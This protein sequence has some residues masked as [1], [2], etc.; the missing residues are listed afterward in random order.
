MEPTTIPLVHII[1]HGQALHNVDRGYPHRDPPLTDAGHEA[2]K[3]I[4]LSA[5]PDLI[6]ISPMTR[7]IQTAMNAFPSISTDTCANGPEVQI[8]P[9]L[10]EAH[11]AICNKGISRADISTKFPHLNFSECPEE[12]DHPPHTIEA[13]GER[14]EKVRRRLKELSKVYNNIAL[15]THRGFI[16]FL[17]KGDRYDV[18]ETRSYRFGTDEEN[19]ADSLRFG[20]NVDTK[21]QQDFGPTVLIPHAA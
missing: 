20:V 16:A 13:A 15:I 17:A 4:K 8:W 14:A 7:T 9:D 18:C 5:V 2:T 6:V 1:R 11:D 19:E 21:G 10:R 12:W 3:R